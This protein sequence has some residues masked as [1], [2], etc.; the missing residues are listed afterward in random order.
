MSNT[1]DRVKVELDKALTATRK[2]ARIITAKA[3]ETAKITKLSIEGM[4]LDHRMSKKFAELGNLAYQN[5][6]GKGKEGLLDN[7]KG[8]KVFEELKKLEV[9]LNK[10]HKAL[11]AEKKKKY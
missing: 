5:M 6:K 9:E 3:G 7:A 1:W 4:T 10:N 8:K 2:T 11:Q